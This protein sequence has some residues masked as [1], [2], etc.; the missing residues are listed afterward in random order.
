MGSD[1]LASRLAE[2]ASAITYG[3][4]KSDRYN[5]STASISIS[6]M[7]ASISTLNQSAQI[8]IL[9]RWHSA[10]WEDYIALRDAPTPERMRL[11]FNEGWL[12]VDMGAEGIN[13]ASISDLF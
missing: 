10:V 12:W 6:A 9:H 11:F 4:A 8:P 3:S 13:H 1:C 5:F 7:T 2:L